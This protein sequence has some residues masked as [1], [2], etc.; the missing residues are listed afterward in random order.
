MG[1]LNTMNRSSLHE[2]HGYFCRWLGLSAD[3]ISNE[4][5]DGPDTNGNNLLSSVLLKVSSLYRQILKR[6][7]WSNSEIG[8]ELKIK[9][10]QN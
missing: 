2:T 5:L 1:Y 7:S 8:I 10:G 9:C 4:R 6:G 3:K